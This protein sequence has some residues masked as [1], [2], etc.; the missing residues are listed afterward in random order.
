MPPPHP[1]PQPKPLPSLDKED[2]F[3]L[4]LVKDGPL[5]ART[6][7]LQTSTVSTKVGSLL[8]TLKPFTSTPHPSTSVG[9]GPVIVKLCDP[10]RLGTSRSEQQMYSGLYWDHRT[11][12][13][14]PQR[15]W[16][17]HFQ[18]LTVSH[19]GPSPPHSPLKLPLGLLVFFGKWHWR[20]PDGTRGSK[21]LYEGVSWSMDVLYKGKNQ[22]DW[23]GRS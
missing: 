2:V 18:G 11:W 23:D 20:C 19:R 7:T 6:D 17:L 10:V 22:V 12:L 13:V 15:N 1:R 4:F 5:S 14:V 21:P 3:D 16:T 9:P 8:T